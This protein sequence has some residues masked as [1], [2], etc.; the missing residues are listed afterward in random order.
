MQHTPG[1]WEVY[2]ERNIRP[3]ANSGSVFD[4]IAQVDREPRAANA[5]LMAASP[6]LLAAL[7]A[8]RPLIDVTHPRAA[9]VH[10][11]VERALAKATGN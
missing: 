3:V 1:P 7:I 9:E 2:G 11:I 10:R 6:D 8:A 5:T 4:D